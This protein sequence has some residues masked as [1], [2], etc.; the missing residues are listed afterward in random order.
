MANPYVFIVGC[1]RSGTT[2]LLRMINAHPQITIMREA[3]WISRVLE[4]R[5][6]LTPEGLVKPELIPYLCSDPKFARL[7]VAAE[8]LLGLLR[9]GQPVSFPDLV[10]RI[11]DLYGQDKGKA[12]VGNKTP[13]VVRRIP[14][15]HTLWPSAR[16]IHLIRDGRDVCLSMADWRK[17]QQKKPGI[18]VTWKDDPV[19]TTALWWELSVRLGREVGNSLGRELYYEMRYESLVSNPAKE[20]AALCGFLGVPYDEAMLRFHESRTRTKPGRDAKHGW[21]PI[22]PGLRDWRSQMLGE[23]LERFEAAAGELLDELGY[24]RA[25]QRPR[26]EVLEQASKVRA[27]LAQDSNWNEV[28]SRSRAEGLDPASRIP[29]S[30]AEDLDAA[31]SLEGMA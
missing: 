17:A 11:F 22:T 20:C 24:G 19:S 10:A 7:H 18:F 30:R 23:D 16:F 28:V 4:E 26:P 12:L 25:V 1:A 15:F 14:T 8:E 29:D 5:R 27:S 2:L 9:R 6:D 31:G 13:S 21:L 3:H